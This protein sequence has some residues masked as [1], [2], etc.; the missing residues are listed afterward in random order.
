VRRGADQ[1]TIVGFPAQCDMFGEPEA[2]EAE[3]VGAR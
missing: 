3:P 2:A 1:D